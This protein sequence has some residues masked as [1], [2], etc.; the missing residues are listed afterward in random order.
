MKQTRFLGLAVLVLWAPAA[1]AHTFGAHG[2]GF[3][4]GMAHPFTGL[5]HL[6][7]MTAYGLL[8]R[9]GEPFGPYPLHLY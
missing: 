8:N 9:E 4:Q 3:M 6:L 5:D 2:A 1:L 7:A